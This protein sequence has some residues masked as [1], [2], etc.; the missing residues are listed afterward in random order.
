M[1]GL[2]WRFLNSIK[3]N[4]TIRFCKGVCYNIGE[5]NN[6]RRALSVIKAIILDKDGT[7]I[8][9]GQTWDKPSVDATEYLLEKS[10]MNEEKKDNF[11]K[12]LGIEGDKIVANSIFAAGSIEDQAIE[13]SKII[14]MDKEEI[15]TYLED[16]YLDYVQGHHEHVVAMSGAKEALDVLKEKYILAV[17]TND[18]LRIAEE[19]L[20]LAGL[21]GYFDFVAGADDFGPKPNPAALFEFAKRFD[22]QLNEMV[23]VGD[24][25]VDMQYGK[26]TLASIGLAIEE[27]H[28]DHLAGADY[29]MSHFDELKGIIERIESSSNQL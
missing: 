26:H 4:T 15:E 10:D 29:I 20:R 24:S 19:T 17:V 14:P 18:N 13:F 8:E 12:H 7:L 27:S 6:L 1:G 2:I 9:L 21:E 3:K 16:V 25:T 5:F 22:V 23:Y 28:R 11:R